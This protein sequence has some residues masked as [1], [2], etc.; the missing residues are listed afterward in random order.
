MGS[1][2]DLR[3][4]LLDIAAMVACVGLLVVLFLPA[5]TWVYI[6]GAQLILPW[7]VAA[8]GAVGVVGVALVRPYRIWPL[9]L[10]VTALTCAT[11]VPGFDLPNTRTSCTTDRTV[12]V[13]A[14]NTKQSGGSAADVL[15]A[16]KDVDADILSISELTPERI[17]DLKRE[18]KD[19]PHNFG[20]GDPNGFTGTYL[21]SKWPLTQLD[22]SVPPTGKYFSQPRATIDTPHGQVRVAA[23]HIA[24]PLVREHPWAEGLADVAAFGA[25]PG[26]P[27]IA[28]GDFNSMPGHV[29][30]RRMMRDGFDARDRGVPWRMTWGPLGFPAV[31]KLDHIVVRGGTLAGEDARHLANSDHAIVSATVCLNDA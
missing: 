31:A 12:N 16:A 2:F 22:S 23:V 29:E 28:L 30:F 21:F 13:M 6:A 9:A 1:L 5:N 25:S 11:L 7:V 26:P 14:A 15:A 20:W 27:V 8:V 19:Y 10:V 18:L 4:R 17:D 24:P 3:P